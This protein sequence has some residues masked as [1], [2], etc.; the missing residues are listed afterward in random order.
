VLKIL[1][2]LIS[3]IDQNGELK[4]SD[5]LDNG[6]DQSMLATADKSTFTLN[7]RRALVVTNRALIQRENDKKNRLEEA[8]KLKNNNNN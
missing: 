3:I 2:K 7:Q 5:F 4:D 1:P 8:S 6:I